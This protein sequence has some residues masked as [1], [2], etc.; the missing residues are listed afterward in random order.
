MNASEESSFE[1]ELAMSVTV[2]VFSGR[3]YGSRSQKNQKVT[4]TKK[5]QKYSRRQREKS[6]HERRSY[7]PG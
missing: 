6:H 3:L 7:F 1:E 4:R 2:T 5:C